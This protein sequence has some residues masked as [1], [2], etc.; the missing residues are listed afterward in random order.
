M[1]NCKTSDA[2][3]ASAIIAGFICIAIT[4]LAIPAPQTAPPLPARLA[5]APAKAAADPLPPQSG[6]VYQVHF[7]C[8]G[9]AG[10]RL[11]LSCDNGAGRQWNLVLRPWDAGAQ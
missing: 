5:A 2:W 11:D 1:S 3:V 9:G 7:F 10:G 6:I 4:T 8:P